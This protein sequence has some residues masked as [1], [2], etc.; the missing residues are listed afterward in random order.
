[1]SS[2]IR[3]D[4]D[5]QLAGGPAPEVRADLLRHDDLSQTIIPRRGTSDPAPLSFAQ[6]RLWY[7][8]QI[9][10]EAASAHLARGLKITGEID[11][12]RLRQSLAAVVARHDSLRA[13][14]ATTQLYAGVDGQPVQLIA[15]EGKT[16]LISVD[17]SGIAAGQRIERARELAREEAQ[18]GF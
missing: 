17:L 1:M 2:S 13:T 14:F 5:E 11:N 9:D 4:S 12:Q 10:P 16:E 6:E 18:R 3:L 7:L 15:P 8:D